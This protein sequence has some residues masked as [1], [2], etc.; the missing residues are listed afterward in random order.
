[1]STVPLN[2]VKTTDFNES[3]TVAERNAVAIASE[4]LEDRDVT[5][6]NPNWRILSN[7]RDKDRFGVIDIDWINGDHD[8]DEGHDLYEEI[9]G[10]DQDRLDSFIPLAFQYTPAVPADQRNVGGFSTVNGPYPKD[11]RPR[12][13]GCM[14]LLDEN[15]QEFFGVAVA[16]EVC[17]YLGLEHEEAQDNLMEEHGGITG[18][19]LTWA[20]WDKIRQH[21]MMKWL[22]PDI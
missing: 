9:S 20:Q 17:H 15:D 18:H 5:I 22:A 2:A 11:D 16:H 21:G 13:S 4:I 7:Q 6:Y 8:F 3:Q 19:Q 10:P 1:M 14:V 12:T